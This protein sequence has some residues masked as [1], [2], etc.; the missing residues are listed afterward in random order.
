MVEPAKLMIGQQSLKWNV[1]II[2]EF[3]GAMLVFTLIYHYKGLAL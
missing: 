1:V 2:G 3:K